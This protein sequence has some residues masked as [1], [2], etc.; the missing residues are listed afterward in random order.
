VIQHFGFR[1]AFGTAAALA[2]ISVLSFIL[3]DRKQR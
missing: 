1:A 3:V 2:A